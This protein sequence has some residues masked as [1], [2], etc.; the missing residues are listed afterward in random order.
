[1]VL[2]CTPTTIKSKQPS[3]LSLRNLKSTNALICA[4]HNTS[5]QSSDSGA[6]R[7]G[8]ETYSN[9]LNRKGKIHQE[10]TI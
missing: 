3:S 6:V 4:Q 5:S 1:M 8:I 2:E 9:E 10:S 7:L